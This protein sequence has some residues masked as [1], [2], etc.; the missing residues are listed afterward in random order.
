MLSLPPSQLAL[1]PGESIVLWQFP[2]LEK[3]SR[4]IPI[5]EIL[6]EIHTGEKLD[7]DHQNGVLTYDQA[8]MKNSIRH[9]GKRIDLYC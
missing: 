8:G 1:P 9:K 5:L 7:Y 2:I 4:A 3:K 6:P